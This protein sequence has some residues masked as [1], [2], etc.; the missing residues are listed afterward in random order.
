MGSWDVKINLDPPYNRVHY[1]NHAFG[2]GD[3]VAGKVVFSPKSDESIDSIYIEFKGK[4]KT[5]HGRGKDERKYE[6]QMFVMKEYF[7][8]GTVQN[9]GSDV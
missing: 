4:C 8:Q 1:R 3:K 2:P 6:R 5:Q 7:V 9:E